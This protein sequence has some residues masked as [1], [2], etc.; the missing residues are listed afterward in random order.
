MSDKY[1]TDKSGL[2]QHLQPGDNVTDD[3]GFDI[4][5]ILSLGVGLNIPPIKGSRGPLTA[6]EMDETVNIAFVGIHI[7]F[8]IIGRITEDDLN[9]GH[10]SRHGL[11]KLG[12]KAFF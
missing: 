7:R 8:V 10:L 6:K 3:R 2:I 9:R 11:S 1:I 5:D 4:H 12:N